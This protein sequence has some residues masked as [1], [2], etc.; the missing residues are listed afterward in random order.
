MQEM[1]YHNVCTEK[2]KWWEVY[3]SWGGEGREEKLDISGLLWI[4]RHF[5]NLQTPTLFIPESFWFG[6]ITQ[7][8]L[9]LQYIQWKTLISFSSIQ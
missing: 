2:K 3:R 1:K 4:E 6:G 7:V 5:Q 9:S 8:A